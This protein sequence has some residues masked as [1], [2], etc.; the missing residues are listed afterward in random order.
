MEHWRNDVD[1]VLGVESCSRATLFNEFDGYWPG[2]E[3][4]PPRLEVGGRFDAQR[5]LPSQWVPH[6][7][8]HS[9]RE[10]IQSVCF[11][12]FFQN[13]NIEAPPSKYQNP[14]HIRPDQREHTLRS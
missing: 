12:V 10:V 7:E 5:C 6:R 8:H 2:I 4:G 3:S 9:W 11:P 14:P 13:R 1:E